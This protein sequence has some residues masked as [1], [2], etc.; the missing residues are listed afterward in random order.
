MNPEALPQNTPQNK[1]LSP[2]ALAQEGLAAL[3]IG[4][5]IPA[6]YGPLVLV[7]VGLIIAAFVIG[8]VSIVRSK[9]TAGILLIAACLFALFIAF[10]MTSIDTK[11]KR[12]AVLKKRDTALERSATPETREDVL[13]KRDAVL[14]KAGIEP[15]KT[16]P[17]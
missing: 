15:P 16:S 9:L 1:K 4:A 7:S 8:V 17:P 10:V 3:V 12:D 6:F 14:R 5:I 11:E 13:K 2:T